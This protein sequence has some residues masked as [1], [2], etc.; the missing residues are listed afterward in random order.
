MNKKI[1]IS[2]LILV[3]IILVGACVYFCVPNNVT[4]LTDIKIINSFDNEIID[5]ENNKM[6]FTIKN[7]DKSRVVKVNGEVYTENRRFYEPG[8][9]KIEIRENGRRNVLVVNIKDIEKT[10]ESEYNIY[11]GSQML[12]AFMAVLDMTEKEEVQGFFWT[13][14]SSSLNLENI[15]E[16]APNLKISEYMGNTSEDVYKNNL[17]PEVKEYIKSILQEDENA[18][19][20]LYVD[21]YRFYSDTEYFAKIGITDNRYNYYFYSDGTLSYVKDFEGTNFIVHKEYKMREENGYNDFLEYKEQYFNILEGIRSNQLE[22]NKYPGSYMVGEDGDSLIY[23]YLLIATLR[24][25]VQYLLQFPQLIDYK[26]E[27][28]ASEME[29]ANLIKIDLKEQYQNLKEEQQQEFLKNINLDKQSLDEKYFKDENEK[30]LI[31]TGAKPFYSS[32][33]KEK[34]ENILNE[35]YKEYGEEYTLLYKPH[36]S[37]LPDEEQQKFLE[38]LNIQVLPGRIPMEAIMFIYPNVKIGGFPSTLYLSAEEGQTL[39]FI[40][41]NKETLDQP[42]EQLYDKLFTGSKFYN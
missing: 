39:F 17:I 25:N 8:E 18:F 41:E 31:I 1:L 33:G 2:V 5:Y 22:Y 19:F 34:F 42:L 10:K 16:K 9:Y 30:Y 40:E 23:D 13:Q 37:A 14:K 38:N 21:E 28:V 26:D 35:I 27:R 6:P 11:I 12:P 20:N 15:K 32:I 3:A 24:D 36:P 4:A 7:I 29:N